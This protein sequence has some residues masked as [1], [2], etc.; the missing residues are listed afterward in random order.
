MN[1]LD[2][3]SNILRVNLALYFVQQTW[4]LDIDF[5]SN[6]VNSRPLSNRIET[7]ALLHDVKAAV[8]TL[9]RKIFVKSITFKSFYGIWQTKKKKRIKKMELC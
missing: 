2:F 8:I 5:V 7:I 9:Q 3:F 6:N 1:G 4:L